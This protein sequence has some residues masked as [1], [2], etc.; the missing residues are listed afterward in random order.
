MGSFSLSHW[1]VVIG[2]YSTVYVAS[3]MILHFHLRRETVA[4]AAESSKGGAAHQAP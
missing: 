2:C 4:P 3:P 1:L